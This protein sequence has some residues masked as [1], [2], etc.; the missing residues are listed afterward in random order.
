MGNL[1]QLVKEYITQSGGQFT[2]KQAEALR[3]VFEAIIDELASVEERVTI[4]EP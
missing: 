3:K 4:L 1:D 2:V